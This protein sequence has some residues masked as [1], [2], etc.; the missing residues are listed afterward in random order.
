M[1]HLMK[2]Q[3]DYKIIKVQQRNLRMMADFF[4]QFK[5]LS[6]ADAE[7]KQAEGKDGNILHQI[8][9]MDTV[10]NEQGLSENRQPLFSTFFYRRYPIRPLNRE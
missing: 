6:E 7:W 3:N 10:E 4:G 1:I 8:S 9:L 2:I 5:I